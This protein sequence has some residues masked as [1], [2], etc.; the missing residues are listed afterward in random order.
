MLEAVKSLYNLQHKTNASQA[1]NMLSTNMDKEIVNISLFR[2]CGLPNR[3]KQN[4][5]MTVYKIG[6]LPQ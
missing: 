1:S 6:I 4:S 5:K 2:F 3:S